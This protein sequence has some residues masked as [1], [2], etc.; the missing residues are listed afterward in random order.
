MHG[1]DTCHAWKFPYFYIYTPPPTL[2][3]PSM[4]HCRG[5]FGFLYAFEAFLL[6]LLL[7]LIFGV[8]NFFCFSFNSINFLFDF[9]EKKNERKCGKPSASQ[10]CQSCFTCLQK[11]LWV[12]WFLSKCSWLCPHKEAG[13]F[14]FWWGMVIV[15]FFSWINNSKFSCL[16]LGKISY[17]GVAELLLL[18]LLLCRLFGHGIGIHLLQSENPESLPKKSVINPKDNHLSF[19]VIYLISLLILIHLICFLWLVC[20]CRQDS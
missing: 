10:I 15:F 8:F 2:T 13:F 18:L 20:M 7:L 17:V 9:L 1:R 11:H 6:L 3:Y 19:Q 4:K 14:Q 5:L 16:F 12:H